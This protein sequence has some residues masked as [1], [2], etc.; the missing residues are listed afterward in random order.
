MKCTVG[1]FIG[2]SLANPA[3]RLGVSGP[4]QLFETYPFLLPC[5]FS[6]AYNLGVG[7]AAML[8]LTETSKLAGQAAV[9]GGDEHEEQ[10]SPLLPP[11]T[12]SPSTTEY[13]AFERSG[14]SATARPL[15][16]RRAQGF[17]LLSSL[18]VGV[19]YFRRCIL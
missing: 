19:P 10:Q 2:G 4:G 6:T 11:G 8:L 16:L 15:P 7:A 18:Y 12:D 17:L 9:H 1:P 5:L 3:E 14:E 13:G